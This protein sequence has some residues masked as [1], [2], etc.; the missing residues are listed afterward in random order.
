MTVEAG[1]GATCAIRSD[2]HL[3][4]FGDFL[5][6]GFSALPVLTRLEGEK[7]RDVSLSSQGATVLGFGCALNE[8]GDLRCWGLNDQ[9]TLAIGSFGDKGAPA[10]VGSEL[11]NAIDAVGERSCGVRDDA[12]LWCWGRT[13]PTSVQQAPARI[14]SENGWRSVSLGRSHQCALKLDGSLWCWGENAA[15][16]LGLGDE[17]VAQADAP[18][19]VG[20]AADWT[21]IAP[22][23]RHTCGLRSQ[24]VGSGGTLWCWGAGIRADAATSD[25]IAPL[26]IGA[27]QDW[28]AVTSNF[29]EA[30]APLF[31]GIRSPGALYCWNDR[32]RTPTRLGA[33][34]DWTAV[35][36]GVGSTPCGIRAPG[37]L[38]CMPFDNSGAEPRRIGSESD[39][40]AISLGPGLNCG[41]RQGGALSC[42]LTDL[43]AIDRGLEPVP[44]SDPTRVGTDTGW[45]SVAAGGQH[46][47]ALKSDRRL[48]CWGE[49]SMGR[50]GHGDA[51]RDPPRLAR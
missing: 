7:W 47:C 6:F 10:Q 51:W 33:D 26:Q 27:D 39:W 35:Q 24:A 16:A 2:H 31:C 11:W 44:L 17:R 49:G 12:S 9:G 40:V 19:R 1:A 20:T 13:T 4:C 43:S 23:T 34:S 42:W 21:T 48:F 41:V 3:D 50:L 37:A 46:A 14:G 30:G 38:W 22:G 8:T 15:G 28:L 5:G 45:S 36:A 32:I 29:N 25:A 18:V